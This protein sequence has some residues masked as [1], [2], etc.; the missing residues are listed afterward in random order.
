MV[1]GHGGYVHGSHIV[2]ACIDDD[3]DIDGMSDMEHETVMMRSSAL[4]GKSP[5]IIPVTRKGTSQLRMTLKSSD[6]R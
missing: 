2:D 3:D 1:V 4:N 5:D 6:Y